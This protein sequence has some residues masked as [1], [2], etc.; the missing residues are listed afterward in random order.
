MN[1][2]IT[3]GISA[4]WCGIGFYRGYSS[5]EE[6]SKN[7]TALKSIGYGFTGM[8]LYLNPIILPLLIENE[9]KYLKHYLKERKN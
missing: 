7:K 6:C 4:S 1:K 3:L 9:Y 8:I 2:I 5:Y